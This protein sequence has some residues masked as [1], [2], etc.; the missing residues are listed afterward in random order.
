MF[1]ILESIFNSGEYSQGQLSGNPNASI[2]DGV[3]V[4]ANIAIILGVG[5]STFALAYSL[6]MYITSAGDPKAAQ[7][8]QHALT[9]AVIGLIV[10][11][12]VW[13]IKTAL[14][15]LMGVSDQLAP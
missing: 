13:G 3:T 9:W 1:D 6:I 4:F 2:A 15:N 12:I 14:L 11:S 10:C 7:K 5:L 8:A